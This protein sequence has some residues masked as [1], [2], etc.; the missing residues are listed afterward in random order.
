ME[1]LVCT[2]R[3]SLLEYF[4]M[5]SFSEIRQ[6]LREIIFINCATFAV[7]M[8]R[9]PGHFELSMKAKNAETK[10]L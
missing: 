8:C 10:R 2:E 9:T 5:H 4:L 3:A 6:M 7:L 1:C